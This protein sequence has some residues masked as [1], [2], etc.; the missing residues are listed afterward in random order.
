MQTSK[1]PIFQPKM[2]SSLF[3]SVLCLYLLNKIVPTC[4]SSSLDDPVGRFRAYLKIDTVHPVPDYMPPVEFIL[5]Q[6]KEIGL[7]SQKLEYVK[8]KPVV[9]LTWKGKDSSL[10]SILLNSHVDVV[11]AEKEKWV[12]D[13]FA[14]VQV[15]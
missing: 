7:E 15:R 5:S 11:P 1:A 4:A 3:A 2:I 9:L 14:A 10:P 6:A 12:H 13:P 8:G